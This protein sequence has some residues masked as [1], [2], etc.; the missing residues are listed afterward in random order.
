MA[1]SVSLRKPRVKICCISSIDEAD[2]AIS[3]GADALG[4]VSSMPSGPGVVDEA[5]IAAIALRVP[6]SVATFLLTALQDADAI[7]EQH[8]RCLT[9]TLQLVDRVEPA[10]LVR[11]RAK[12][13]P[14]IKVVQVVHVVD[15]DSVAEALELAPLVDALLLDSGNPMAAVKELGGTGRVHDWQLSR[16][17]RENVDV[18]VFLAGGL[19]AENVAE[20]IAAV[21]PFGLDLCSSVRQSGA[22]HPMKLDAFMSA[23]D[24]VH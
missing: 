7:V 1:F 2:L 10:E 8:V 19:R 16:E 22:L 20:A 3:A 4:L 21:R 5:T 13:P 18:P 15:R 12:L 11:L 17:I 23:V 6:P 9:S 24:A 14:G